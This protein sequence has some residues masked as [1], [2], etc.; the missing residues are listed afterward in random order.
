MI[1]ITANKKFHI[2]LSYSVCILFALLVIVSFKENFL[3][4]IQEY[5]YII[6]IISFSYA[7]TTLL[8]KNYTDSALILLFSCLY[9]FIYLYQTNYSYFT[10]AF[11]LTVPIVNS[12]VYFFTLHQINK[13]TSIRAMSTYWPIIDKILP[14]LLILL[15]SLIFVI[16]FTTLTQ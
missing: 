6:Y 14:G 8:Q 4:T 15:S 13:I 3:N 5:L 11:Y 2:I 7:A 1:N 12:F 9:P 16:I 10:L